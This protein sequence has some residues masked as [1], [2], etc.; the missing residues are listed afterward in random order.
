MNNKYTLGHEMFTKKQ[1]QL[2]QVA[3][4][5][6]FD[7]VVQRTGIPASSLMSLFAVTEKGAK[8][9]NKL[10]SQSTYER[11]ME[12]LGVNVGMDGLRKGVVLLWQC[13]QKTKG[14]QQWIEAVAELKKNLFIGVQELTLVMEKKGFLQ[15]KERMVFVH[16]VETGVR[17]VFSGIKKNSLR[18]LGK[19]FNCEIK[20]ADALNPVDFQFTKSLITNNVYRTTQFD[21]V[22]GGKAFRYS[23]IDVQAAAKEFNFNPDNLID[24]MVDALQSVRVSDPVFI[25][26]DGV[27]P[28]RR[29][30]TG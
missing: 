12:L 30:V 27:T 16:D 7:E 11:L 6:A 17:I 22:L 3:R 29:V 13:P 1:F 20:L 10:I 9:P 23:W 15:R 21:T 8:D 19:I 4:G 25:A 28:I 5:L 24:L 18:E 2:I 26:S 14:Q